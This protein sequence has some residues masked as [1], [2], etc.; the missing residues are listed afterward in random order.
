MSA[1][2][3]RTV[4]LSSAST[5]Q[6]TGSARLAAEQL[7]ITLDA[8]K[9]QYAALNEKDK[10]VT[11]RSLDGGGTNVSIANRSDISS[12][13]FSPDGE[14]LALGAADGSVKLWSIPDGTF[15]SEHRGATGEVGSIAFSADNRLLAIGWTNGDVE[16]RRTSDGATV[17][18][19]KGHTKIVRTLS[20][21][22]D[23]GTLASGAEDR[24]IRLW[25][26]GEN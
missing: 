15:I 2:G 26:N 6:R 3:D 1:A 10:S 24:T 22:R 12:G 23:G 8:T 9:R 13:A 17:Q 5:L 25:K 18:T 16:L 20:F 19:L 14:T 11:V 21:S 4:R 7:L